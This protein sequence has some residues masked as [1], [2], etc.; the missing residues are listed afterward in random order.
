[1]TIFGNKE[2]RNAGE[3]IKTLIFHFN[4]CLLGFLIISRPGTYEYF[5]VSCQ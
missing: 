1:M 4:S 3:F 2:A 5:R